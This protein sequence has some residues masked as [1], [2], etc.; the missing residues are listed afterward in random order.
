MHKTLVHPISENVLME[1]RLQINTNLMTGGNF[2]TPVSSI[3]GPS[4]PKINKST[5]SSE[6]NDVLY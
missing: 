5:E 4:G 6:L 2:S 3:D 1:L